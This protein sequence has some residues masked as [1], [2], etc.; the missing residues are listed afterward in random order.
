MAHMSVTDWAKFV[1]V[2]LRADPANPHRQITLLKADTF[3]QLYEPG[4]TE[5]AAGWYIGSKPW[6][7]GPRPGDTGRVL[8]HAGDNG[9]W[10]IVVWVAPEIDFAILI[11]CNRGGMA[12][13]ID[14]VAG[15]LLRFVPKSPLTK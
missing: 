13:P 15:A 7:K 4:E 5:Y 12:D 9:R 2:Y 3:A 10:S 1:A 11:A 6:A 14:E 8:F